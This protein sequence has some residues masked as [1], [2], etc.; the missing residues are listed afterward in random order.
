M[1]DTNYSVNCARMTCTCEDFKKRRENLAVNDPLRAC[2]HIF[3]K[4]DQLG[5]EAQCDE[6]AWAL[7][8]AGRPPGEIHIFETVTGT[9]YLLHREKG[10][11][12][13]NVFTRT[14]RK[15]EKDGLYSG[16]Y[17]EFGYSIS[18]KRWSYGSGPPGAKEIKERLQNLF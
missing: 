18:G 6:L 14:R 8:K 5:V 3:R 12:W 4:L 16:P 1:G 11:D 2:K 10:A 7:A 13:V 17:G 9:R 15:G